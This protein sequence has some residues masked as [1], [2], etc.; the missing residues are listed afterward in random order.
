MTTG[1]KEQPYLKALQKRIR[2]YRAKT[3]YNEI[4]PFVVVLDRDIYMKVLDEMNT[5]YFTVPVH[6][7]TEC[8]IF[9]GVVIFP[10]PIGGSQM[11]KGDEKYCVLQKINI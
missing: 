6:R 10:D 9:Q 7:Y 5:D 1:V 8:S 11:L 3:G 4:T 2:E